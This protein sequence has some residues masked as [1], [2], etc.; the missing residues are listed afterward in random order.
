MTQIVRYVGKNGCNTQEYADRLT[1]PAACVVDRYSAERNV[2]IHF[3]GDGHPL[4]VPMT[5]DVR[6]FVDLAMCVYIGDEV[7][8]R[9]SAP[10]GWM[11]RFDV[12]APVMEPDRWSNISDQITRTLLFLA[13]DRYSFSFLECTG[14]PKRT[15]HRLSLPRNFDTVCLFSGGID[16]L[17]GAYRL[18][19]EGRRVL[20]V[21][22]QAEPIT[23]SAQ[24]D[25]ADGLRRKFPDQVC[26]IQCRVARS[27]NKSPKFRL[28]AKV[29]ETHRPRSFLFLALAV[30]IARAAQVNEIFMPENGL[31]ALNPPLQISRVGS[32]ST[33]TAHPVFLTRFVDTLNAGGV[34]T[35]TIR[36]PF[37]YDSK[38]DMLR[39]LDP[40]LIDMVQRS[41]SCSH[42]SRFHD[43]GVRHCGYC[44]PC[45]YRRTAMMVCGLDRDTDYAFDVW[46]DRRSLRKKRELSAYA[47]SDVRAMVPF[48]QRVISATQ[49]ELETLVLFHGYFPPTVGDRIGLTK[50][51]NYR[52]WTEMMRR[53]A[54]EFLTE[55]PP[56]S[57]RNRMQALGLAP[58]KVPSP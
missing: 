50:A 49:N 10:D 31:I 30:A 4:F 28:P 48:A 41:V 38:S 55:T 36:N 20:L 47:Q 15:R 56:R 12:L 37:L 34:F 54:D 58:V 43:E 6:D 18:L 27:K 32:H 9:E 2:T 45:L 7:L 13:Q 29:E 25:L 26:L 16:S 52:P 40:A 39:T 42:P 17:L 53:W 11:R 24:K 21:G 3:T 5:A 44:V 35:G 57:T 23:A 22:H 14:V 46:R 19:E 33:R 51:A 8:E 1:D